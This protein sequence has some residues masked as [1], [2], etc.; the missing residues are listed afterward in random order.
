[1]AKKIRK[2]QKL[3]YGFQVSEEMLID[4]EKK[5]HKEYAQASK[6]FTAKAKAYFDRFK[7]EDEEMMQKFKK[8]EITKKQYAEWRTRK[9]QRGQYFSELKKT[10]ASD[11][12]NVDK[13]AM[14]YVNDKAVDV[15][16]LNMNYGTYLLEHESRIDT[17][18]SLYNKEAVKAL[19]KDN[20]KLLPIKKDVDIPLDKRWNMQH[21]QSVITQG[22]LQGESI[23]NIAKRMQR[24]VGMDERAAIRNARTSMTG[25]QNLGRY[26]S[27]T[28]AKEKGV[29]VKKGWLATLDNVTRDSHVDLDGEIQDI[30]KP[31]S[32]G[33]MYPADASGKP[34]EVYN[35]FIPETKIGVDSKIIRSYKHRY[36]GEI[37][38]IK[39]ALGVNFSCTPNHPILTDRGW[40]AAKFLNE[41]D[42]L[43]VTSG[44][45]NEMSRRNPNINHAFPRIDTIHELFYK[46]G[47][48][49]TSDLR[50]NFHGDIPTANV[51][52]ITQK[53]FLWSDF[54]I[55]VRKGINKFLFKY[56]NSPLMRKCSFMEHFGCILRTTFSNIRR[57]SDAFP[58]IKWCISHSCV[59]RLRTIADSNIIF[60]KNTL[61]NLPANV[62][63]PSEIKHRLSRKVF[64]DNIVSV[65][66]SNF[67]GH[68]YNLQTDDNYYFVNSSITNNGTRCNG[69]MAIAHNCRCRLVHQYD[70]Y[71]TDW[72]NVNIRRNDKLGGMTYEEW[73]TKHKV[74]KVLK[75]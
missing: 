49:R 67:V 1:M 35:C 38:S 12:T 2:K 73:K 5:I 20:P 48:K 24:V 25:A 74:K 57:M 19:I 36:E 26:N 47:G 58:F 66:R 15:Y 10:L 64:L 32:N 33:L 52:I 53:G 29:G 50:V 31:F 42:N 37:I 46:L 61:N 51:E 16:A 28:R 69:I 63:L 30:D 55:S 22:I 27:M 8:G 4:L 7:K 71:S 18:F 43:I 41:G 70:K 72:S 9:M 6:E 21:I 68:V 44:V 45:N 59:H 40:V 62:I 3:D 11:L 56:T 39:S 14:S 23:P 75:G 17:S 13:I 54:N 60:G 65:E 34:A